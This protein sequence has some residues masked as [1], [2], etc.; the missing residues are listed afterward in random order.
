MQSLW[1]SYKKSLLKCPECSNEWYEI[2]LKNVKKIDFIWINRDYDS[3]EWILE[4]LADIENHQLNL[5]ASSII[6]EPFIKLHLYMSEAKSDK[7][8]RLNS[9]SSITLK[10]FGGRP[11]FNL[12]S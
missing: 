6:K 10:I 4:L 3:F 2:N 8:I 1:Y 5:I 11:N 9:S 12:V 7:I